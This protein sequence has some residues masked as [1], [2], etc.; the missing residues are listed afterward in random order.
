ML[1]LQSLSKRP[2]LL[3]L[4]H[5][6]VALGPLGGRG[7]PLMED[8]LWWKTTY[9]KRW[10]LTENNI[11]QKTTFDRRQPLTEDDLW[12]KTNFDGRWPLTEEDL[13]RKTT[14]DGTQPC[15][16]IYRK[17]DIFMQRRLMQI[18]TWKDLRNAEDCT[19]RWTYYALRY[20]LWL[21]LV[22]EAPDTHILLKLWQGREE[23]AWQLKWGSLTLFFFL[24]RI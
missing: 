6:E 16:H 14:F 11:W 3:C 22:V 8:D 19:R 4:I 10:L 15:V 7:R 20:F 23:P 9:N 13:L 24:F 18:F 17:D 2:S 5:F 21:R 12:W 1:S